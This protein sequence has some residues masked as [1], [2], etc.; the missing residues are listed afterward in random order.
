MHR[1][2]LQCKFDFAI[3]AGAPLTIRIE[4]YTSNNIHI[5]TLFFLVSVVSNRFSI[6]LPC[7]Y[8][9][10]P[11]ISK[12]SENIWIGWIEQFLFQVFATRS[13]LIIWV[14][15][16]GSLPDFP[17]GKFAL[18]LALLN[19]VKFSALSDLR[20]T[21]GVKM[22]LSLPRDGLLVRRDRDKP[23]FARFQETV[24]MNFFSQHTQRVFHPKQRDQNI[25]RKGRLKYCFGR[26]FR[27]Q[28]SHRLSEKFEENSQ[29]VSVK[30]TMRIFLK[31]ISS[32]RCWC[33]RRGSNRCCRGWW[34]FINFGCKSF[35]IAFKIHRRSFY[36]CM[37]SGNLK[38]LSVEKCTSHNIPNWVVYWRR[39]LFGCLPI[40]H[41]VSR[42]PFE[43][44]NGWIKIS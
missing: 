37:H 43:G 32:W 6:D 9:W 17:F 39:F 30:C 15:Q 12:G 36:L 20:G 14:S 22:R 23:I 4:I 10:F 24:E 44:L 35:Y 16:G 40:I 33:A 29:F 25:W 19:R 34:V 21:S 8:N 3:H 42:N 27:R 11:F 28:M 18:V 5:L 2:N 13:T 1:S 31:E 26:M 7:V 38:N 41:K